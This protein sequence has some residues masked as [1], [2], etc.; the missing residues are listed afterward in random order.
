REHLIGK[1]QSACG[2]AKFKLG[3][4]DDDAARLCVIRSSLVNLHAQVAQ[5]FAEFAARQR[6][7]AI[8]RDVF[9]V[10]A[11]GLN[12]GGENR[13]RQLVRFAQSGGQLD[14]ADR[15]VG[16]VLLPA[17]AGKIAAHHTLDGDHVGPHHQHR[18]AMQLAGIF[19]Q[20]RR[21]LVH[22]GGDEV[23]GDD[24]LEELEPEKRE[25]RQHSSLLRYAG[26]QHIVECRDAIGRHE[27]QMFVT[28]LVKVANFSAGVEFQTG[29]VGVQEDFGILS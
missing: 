2:A 3:I 6:Y 8:E 1:Y 25:L 27:E 20:L 21:V 16:L 19:L 22:V 28:N 12:G 9:V 26:R 4:G 17:R 5:L 29:K 24:A 18:A 7:H 13:L 11:A 10:T 15:T 23:V 14:A